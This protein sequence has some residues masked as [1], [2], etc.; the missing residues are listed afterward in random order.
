MSG[1][2][3]C[4]LSTGDPYSWGTGYLVAS[5][6]DIAQV[7]TVCGLDSSYYLTADI[8]MTAPSPGGSNHT[9][10]GTYAAPFTGY[11]IAGN[12]SISGMVINNP[13][14]T[15]QGFFGRI[16]G[17]TGNG[18]VYDFKLLNATVTA[19]D[20]SGLL[21]GSTYYAD[22]SGLEITGTGTFGNESG[23]LAGIY[24]RGWI[25][26]IDIDADIS[27][28]SK[29][30]VVIGDAQSDRGYGGATLDNI[31]IK[32]SVTATGDKVGAL[33]GSMDIKWEVI[34]DKSSADVTGAGDYVGGLIGYAT[35]LACCGLVAYN[36]TVTGDVVGSGSYVGG[37]IGYAQ[38]LSAIYGPNT[39]SGDVTVSGS[40]SYIGGFIGFQGNGDGVPGSVASGDVSA[41][42]ASKVGGYAG[43]VGNVYYTGAKATGDVVG[44]THVG[45]LIGY[46]ISTSGDISGSQATGSVTATTNAGGLVGTM[47]GEAWD[48]TTYTGI[49]TGAKVRR[50]RASGTVTTGSVGGGLVG[51]VINGSNI[52]ED[53]YARGA[54]SGVGPLGGLVGK[55]DTGSVAGALTLKNSYSMGAVTASSGTAGGLVGSVEAGSAIADTALFWDTQTSGQANSTKGTGKTTADMKLYATFNDAAWSI[56]SGFVVGKTWGICAVNDGYP[57]LLWEGSSSAFC[58]TAPTAL[59]ATPGDGT[60]SISFTPGDDFGSAITNYEYQLDD[61]SWVAL[62]PADDS[63]PITITGLANDTEYSVK[64]RAVNILGKSPASVAVKVTPA[65]PKAPDAPTS[66][67]ATALDTGVKITFTPGAD[68]GATITNY[69]YQLD[70]GNWVA[71]SPADTSSP[72]FIF[73]LTNATQYSIKLRALNSVGNGAASDPVTVTPAAAP[74]PDG[75]SLPELTP[76]TR[77]VLVDGKAVEV[78]LSVE[79]TTDLVLTGDGFELRLTGGCSGGACVLLKD[80]DGNEYMQLRTGGAVEV[81]G[82]GFKPNSIVNVWI[83][84][85]PKYVGKLNVGADGKF[86][87]SLNLPDG[88]TVG[89]HT[90]QVNGWTPEDTERSASLGVQVNRGTLPETGAGVNSLLTLA[91]VLFAAGASLWAISTRRH[92]R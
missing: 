16:S 53:A 29:V 2:V 59:T 72:V 20:R 65:A 88:V 52:I 70:S 23:G 38:Q 9:P 90:L 76:G 77:K 47:D 69:E 66:L 56:G 34:G 39:A 37:A 36:N 49:V 80:S 19:G 11:F 35:G 83:F 54:V 4:S 55:V 27:G 32:G 89:D 79:D 45:G 1:A 26:N 22:L 46:A 82:Y 91:F 71:F 81:S 6:A 25:D 13:A 50:S 78:T 17:Q 74:V 3:A 33:A 15:D 48:T 63:S 73:G 42:N 30:G 44:G 84:S 18:Y 10:I 68:N 31:E 75:A 41:P 24:Y 57:Y 86:T 61:G 92:A 62:S 5:E 7:G 87:G 60:A 67:S 40:G 28:G 14:T 64:I 43:G 85:T 8:T 12:H 21:T 58:M 51:L